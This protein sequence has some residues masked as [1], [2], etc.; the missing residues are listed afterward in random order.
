VAEPDLQS[1][2]AFDIWN[3]E[4][5]YASMHEPLTNLN[6]MLFGGHQNG[7]VVAGGGCF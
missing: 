6:H 4:A 7:M 3:D 2:S 1:S 5:S